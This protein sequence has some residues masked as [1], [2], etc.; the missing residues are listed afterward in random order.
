MVNDAGDGEG[1][2][3]V[4]ADSLMRAAV[5]IRVITAG[6]R[7]GTVEALDDD[8]DVG[9]VRLATVL[10]DFCARWNQGAKKLVG[11]SDVIAQ[12]VRTA[13]ER[14][15]DSDLEAKTVFAGLM[16]DLDRRGL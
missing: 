11:D 15:L 13:V 3:A 5:R 2:Y 1:Y 14:Y 4:V 12:A 7:D 10:A 6:V 9:H 8:V 16:S